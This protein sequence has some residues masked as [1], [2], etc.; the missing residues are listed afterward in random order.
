V[1]H[2]IQTVLASQFSIDHATIQIERNHCTDID[3]K[4][5]GGE[6]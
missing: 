6:P 3:H 2:R 1:L 5:G 4:H